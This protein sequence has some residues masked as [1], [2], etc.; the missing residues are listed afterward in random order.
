MKELWITLRRTGEEFFDDHVPRLSAALA[1]Y[2]IFS[3]APLLL[4]AVSIAGIFFGDDA[5]NGVLDDQL[6]SSMGETAAA[7]VQEML[8]NTRKPADNLLATLTGLVLLVIGAGGVFGQLQDAL[9]TVWGISPKPGRGVKSVLKDRFL[10]FSMVLGIGFLLLTSLA[11]SAFLQGASDLVARV[12]PLHPLFWN[13]LSAIL[14]F[15]VITALFAAILKI[16]PD[17]EIGWRDVV[18]G[19]VFTSVLFSLGKFALGWYL[20]REATSSSYGS[21]GSLVLILLWVYYS[22]TILLLGAEFTQ[23]HASLRG[24]R[25]RPSSGAVR[26][27]KL[28]PE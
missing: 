18:G 6:K 19:A 26:K 3:L 25:I 13:G 12:L 23:V 28:P 11:L 4:I 16:L 9:N 15:F 20:G 22:S 10:S 27:G 2:S 8:A 7:T 1:Y 14:S 24:R 5:A 21:A 17:A